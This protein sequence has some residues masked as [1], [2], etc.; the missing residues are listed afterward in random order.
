MAVTQIS[1]I[2]VRRGRKLSPTGIP[3]LASG[4]VAWAVDSQELFIG[5]GSVAEGAPYV[6]NTK[7][8]TEHDNILALI[9]SYK[10]G[11]ADE[12]SVVPFSVSRSFQSK[13]DEIQVSVVDFG[14]VGDGVADNVDA[15]ET[16]FSQLFQNTVETYRK[17]LVVP[18]GEYVFDS[19]LRVPSYVV[20]MGET[21]HGVTLRFNNGS[22]LKF[23][24]AIGGFETL[25]TF[26]Q[27]LR[28]QYI[29]ISNLV[30]ETAQSDLS[31]AK[32]VL[33]EKVIFKGD[34]TLANPALFPQE[35]TAEVFWANTRLG[36]ETTNLKFK[37]CEFANVEIGLRCDQTTETETKVYF[38]D[39]DFDSVDTGIL[40]IGVRDQVNTWKFN[41]CRFS[42]TANHAL[43]V[44]NGIGMLLRECDF[45]KCGNL[46]DGTPAVPS[47]YF[48][49]SQNNILI[50]CTTDRQQSKGI[51]SDELALYVPEV[52]GADKVTFVTRNRA[53]I[54]IS[55]SFT[56]IAVFSAFNTHMQIKYS[57]SLE[58]G[59]VRDG[60]LSII[61]NKDDGVADLTDNYSYNS[62]LGIALGYQSNTSLVINS[63]TFGRLY[64][65][66][67]LSGE[68]ISLGTKV[69]QL[70]PGSIDPVTGTGTYNVD[71]LPI[72]DP[73][74]NNINTD[75]KIIN[76]TR[77]TMSNIQF[78]AR[79][80]D[81]DD[82]SG[83][84]TV[85]LEY[86]QLSAIRGAPGTISF[87]V[88]YGTTGL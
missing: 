25:A 31:G 2:Q 17:V 10:F 36:Y 34:Y 30:I 49:Q 44:S 47:V 58:P 79:L 7:I 15:F 65:G 12:D 1:R 85:L 88:S 52:Y 46:L 51:T 11:G 76:F 70:N 53:F 73:T 82:S 16:A 14:G 50:E 67:T 23:V 32:D 48:G 72:V 37:S 5:N 9:S 64:Q 84:E 80:V 8:L 69:L 59:D 35:Q 43:F 42:N 26:T 68:N 54:E 21:Q 62:P 75:E 78:Q 61:I 4:E 74:V 56:P 28:P 24:E 22:G 83:A 38:Y 33:F 66:A 71:R 57:M 41:D 63:Y 29:Q 13:I 77:D 39:C 40:V 27:E 6:G 3:Q 18:N 86:R 20:L 19:D 87:D 81:N 45:E 60:V 55:E